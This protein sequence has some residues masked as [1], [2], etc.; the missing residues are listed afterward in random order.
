MPELLVKKP[1]P[2]PPL[3]LPYM[4]TAKVF[5]TVNDPPAETVVVE[6]EVSTMP[7]LVTPIT[8]PLVMYIFPAP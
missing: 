8:P 5:L 2:P 3:L 7:P 6:L 1:A 4:P